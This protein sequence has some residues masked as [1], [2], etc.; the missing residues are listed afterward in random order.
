[1]K[2]NT[3]LTSLLCLLLFVACKKEEVPVNTDEVRLKGIETIFRDGQK[4]NLNIDYDGIG[5]I[6]KVSSSSNNDPAELV[7]DVTYT[8]N[9]IRLIYFHENSSYMTIADTTWLVLDGSQ[10]TAQRRKHI[11][12][13]SSV[14]QE[15]TQRTYIHD[16][17][18]YEYDVA[19]LLKKQTSSIWDSTWHNQGFTRIT[20]TRS[21]SITNYNVQS[22]NVVGSNTITNRTTTSQQLGTRYVS[23]ESQQTNYTYHYSKAYPFKTDFTNA[24]VLNEISLFFGVPASKSN[25]YIPDKIETSTVKKDGNGN[26][27]STDNF[28]YNQSFSYNSYGFVTSIFDERNPGTITNFI[29]TK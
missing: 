17:T 3:A 14:P 5:R 2:P 10:R 13:S 22:N 7:F 26:I 27:T 25:T 28:T 8:N 20:T 11:F 9:I 12:F 6:S 18:N 24:A 19:G 15:P 21:N 23:S 29:Y 4:N 16:T 1:M